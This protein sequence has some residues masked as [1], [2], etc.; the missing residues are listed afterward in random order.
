[1][2]HARDAEP[3][4]GDVRRVAMRTNN[5]T[6]TVVAVA[7]ALL[8]LACSTAAPASA[9]PP[10]A[11]LP[12]STPSSSP[13]ATPLPSVRVT[14]AAQAAALVFASDARWSSMSPLRPDLIGASR[15]YEASAEADGFGVV[16]TAGSGDCLA[17]CI[18]QHRW[19]YHVTPEA[20]VALVREEGDDV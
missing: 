11:T 6:R 7:A 2:P 15:W 17:G 20:D 9:P 14:S 12:T 18:S 3:G 16:I 4:A 8:A 19:I 5:P 13:T 1:M 10:T